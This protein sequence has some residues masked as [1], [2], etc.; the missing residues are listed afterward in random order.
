MCV[1][2]YA[3]SNINIKEEKIKRAFEVN[4]NGAGVMWYDHSGNV[5]Y[6]KGFTKVD[7]LLRFFNSLDKSLPRAIHCRIATS[8]KVSEATCH[9]FPIVEDIEKMK[10]PSGMSETG[11]LMH[12]GIFSHYTPKGGMTSD[13]SDTMEYTSKVVFPV[14]EF[15]DNPGVL[16]L[17][18]EMTSRVLLFLPKFRVLKFGSW[19]KDK[20]EG[21]FASNTSYEKPKYTNYYT[22]DY[23]THPYECGYYGYPKGQSCYSYSP[24]NVLGYEFDILIDAK[25]DKEA[26]ELFM[27]LLED[28]YG[29]F[30]EDDALYDSF[31]VLDDSKGLYVFTIKAKDD[32]EKF[33]PFR[34]KPFT[35]AKRK[36]I[37]IPVKDI[38]KL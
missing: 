32:F 31:R 24:V 22:R 35:I 20:E 19:D 18:N 3:P 5:H 6:V 9:P 28:T 15:I 33:I 8:G 38:S 14:I 29:T 17:L 10:V 13:H 7:Q 30:V 12:N 21:F 2:L 4:S 26:E 27:N 1:I 34:G 16:R 37:F 36:R 11:C 23:Y 25:N